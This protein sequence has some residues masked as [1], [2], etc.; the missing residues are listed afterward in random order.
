MYKKALLFLLIGLIP[1]LF[2]TIVWI[3]T[4]GAFNLIDALHSNP[5][6]VLTGVFSVIGVMFYFVETSSDYFK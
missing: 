1:T 5:N 2:L 3:F 6:I 4:I